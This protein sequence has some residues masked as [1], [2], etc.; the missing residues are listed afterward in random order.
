M[1]LFLFK[2][3]LSQQIFENFKYAIIFE[4][5]K[6][7]PEILRIIKGIVHYL[8]SFSFQNI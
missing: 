6:F 8:D 5:E 4:Y 7:L 3:R 2:I 1:L